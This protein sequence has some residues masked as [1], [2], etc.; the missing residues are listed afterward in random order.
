MNLRLHRGLPLISACLMTLVSCGPTPS[1]ITPNSELPKLSLPASWEATVISIDQIPAG[2][3]QV[4]QMRTYFERSFGKGFISHKLSSPGSPATADVIT[5]NL[6]F[7]MSPSALQTTAYVPLE[8][9]SDSTKG[10]LLKK[11]AYWLHVKD[12]SDL[13]WSS[14]SSTPQGNNLITTLSTTRPAGSVFY[15]R[16]ANTKTERAAVVRNSNDKFVIFYE[17]KSE[18]ALDIMEITYERGLEFKSPIIAAIH[19]I[20]L[21]QATDGAVL[22]PTELDPGTYK[23]HKIRSHFISTET[24]FEGFF[25]HS[26]T[27]LGQPSASDVIIRTFDWGPSNHSYL[28]SHLN[29]P[30]ELIKAAGSSAM[31]AQKKRHFWE[32]MTSTQLFSWSSD[33]MT[34]DSLLG[35]SFMKVL[36]EGT[37]SGRGLYTV[38]SPNGVI[39]RALLEKVSSNELR[40]YLQLDSSQIWGFTATYEMTFKVSP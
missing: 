25:N 15:L 29:L 26:V 21:P 28:E 3:F 40:V 24:R 17:V 37:L 32:K 22:K 14:A 2:Y 9:K 6:D 4:S 19:R 18:G 8:M 7:E 12:N 5:R 1:T 35:D 31:V 34:E 39:S 10:L 33:E 23:I 36:A 13:S 20:A 11:R 27:Q 30:L 38:N 16:N